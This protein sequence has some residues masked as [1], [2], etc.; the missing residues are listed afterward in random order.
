MK[1][2]R[3]A[4]RAH[5]IARLGLAWLVMAT[6]MNVREARS[7]TLYIREVGEGA[8]PAIELVAP[9]RN[10]IDRIK[11][12]TSPTGEVFTADN[13][14][15]DRGLGDLIKTFPT[16]D[17]AFNYLAGTWQGT[18]TRSLTPGELGFQFSIGAVPISSV[19]RGFPLNV[20]LHPGDVVRNGETFV[21]TWDYAT[22]ERNHLNHMWTSALFEGDSI[23]SY[24]FFSIPNGGSGASESGGSTTDGDRTFRRRR[25]RESGTIGNRFLMTYTASE[26]H[27]PLP[28]ELTFGAA[29]ELDEAVTNEPDNDGNPFTNP[30]F[31]QLT[32]LRT[33][34][35]F[36]FL[37]VPEPS[38]GL[39]AV[40]AWLGAGTLRK[41][42]RR[43]GEAGPI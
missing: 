32:Y 24:S 14:L 34:D 41:R 21:M 28:V 22:N 37:L 33:A 6:S 40:G 7:A 29:T 10:S 25:V 31:M 17:A 39:L 5:L 16:L 1:A 38:S 19:Y 9:L 20:S 18:Y 26:A 8:N 35:P 12:L 13:V 27:L 23:D 30:P 42:P 4:V 2:N 3:S 36:Q 15:G 11:T 43:G